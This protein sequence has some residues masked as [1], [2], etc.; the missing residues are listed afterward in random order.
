MNEVEKLLICWLDDSYYDNTKDE[1]VA[2]VTE[3]NITELVNKLNE[4]IEKVNT[5]T[6]LQ[7]E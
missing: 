1:W 3:K 2:K 7:E 5:L 4:V 6:Y